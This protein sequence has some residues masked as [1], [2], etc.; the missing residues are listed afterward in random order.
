MGEEEEDIEESEASTS[1]VGSADGHSD[2]IIAKACEP[3][4]DTDN[5][6]KNVLAN[7]KQDLHDPAAVRQ[8]PPSIL[9]AGLEK[10]EECLGAP[11]STNPR[12][13]FETALQNRCSNN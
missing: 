7:S 2:H 6:R 5:W 8:A 12:A 3:M 9:R 1:E 13:P 4:S 11:V 10:I